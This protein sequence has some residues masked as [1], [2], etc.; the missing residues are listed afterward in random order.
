MGRSGYTSLSI[1]EKKYV[2]LRR[3]FDS[4]VDS[5]KTFT[6]WVMKILETA[7]NREKSVNSNYPGI[8]F[9]GTKTG[10]CILEEKARSSR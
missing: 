3:A 4:I 8:R 5:D 1:K 2:K 6:V 9:V 7:L 10:R